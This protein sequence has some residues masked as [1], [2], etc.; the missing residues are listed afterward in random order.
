MRE[1][2]IVGLFDSLRDHFGFTHNRHEIGIAVPS[3]H[4]VH[5]YMLIDSR[6]CG[7]ADV[8]ADVEA[9]GIECG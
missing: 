4:N 9:V 6:S 7:A 3:R 5:V 2:L 8:H 1:Q